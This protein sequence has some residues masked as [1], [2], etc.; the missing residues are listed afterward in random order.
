MGV[1]KTVMIDGKPVEFRASAAIPRKYRNLFGRDIFQDITHLS[2][3]ID[4][5]NEKASFMDNFSLELFE[6]LAY[7]MYM[8]AHPDEKYASPDEWLDQFQIFSIY[9]I[10]P[11]LIKLWEQN[12]ITLV[13]A[14]KNAESQSG[15]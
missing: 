10:L 7:V 5:Q 3:V 4:G 8:A 9:H 11:E 12:N 14:E 6:D 2:N 15:K 13:S 1:I